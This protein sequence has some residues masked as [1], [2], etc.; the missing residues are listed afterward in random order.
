MH[1]AYHR[2]QISTRIREIGGEPPLIDY[3]YWVWAGRPSPGW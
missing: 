1:T 3:L 2:G